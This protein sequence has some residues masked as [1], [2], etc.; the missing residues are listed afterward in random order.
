MVFDNSS[1]GCV[2]GFDWALHEAVRASERSRAARGFMGSGLRIEG[3]AGDEGRV[4]LAKTGAE[5][6]AIRPPRSPENC[7]E[8][9]SDEFA[10]NRAGDPGFAR[11]GEHV[12]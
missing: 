2:P 12:D 8:L 11:R 6:A 5:W 1:V 3:Y 4:P 9:D 7:V 10:L